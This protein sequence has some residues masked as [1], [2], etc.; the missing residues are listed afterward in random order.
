MEENENKVELIIPPNINDPLNLLSPV[1]KTEYELQLSCNANKK[2]RKRKRYKSGSE[3]FGGPRKKNK[4]GNSPGTHDAHAY[5]SNVSKESSDDEQTDPTWEIT[6]KSHQKDSTKISPALRKPSTSV[7][8]SKASETGSLADTSSKHEAGDPFEDVAQKT[9]ETKPVFQKPAHCQHGNHNRYYGFESLNKNMDVRLKIFQKNIHLFKNKDVL[10][11]GCNCG[12]L[13]LA[14]AKTFSPKSITGIDI[15]RKL[16]NIARSKLRKY[17]TVP[18]RII[19]PDLSC[20]ASKFRHKTECFPI[21]FPICYGNLSLALKQM[22]KKVQT[23]QTLSSTPQTPQ[24]GNEAQNSR[25]PDNISFE[26]VSID[27]FK[28][29]WHFVCNIIPINLHSPFRWTTCL[30]MKL[31]SFAMRENMT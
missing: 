20:D 11:I 23:P 4:T 28:I 13:T 9:D 2:K 7:D 17:V 14:I 24:G 10:D 30:K 27:Y 18:D 8:E 3:F 12:L 26:E 19:D 16:I 25:I 29:M 5:D 15:D 1:D 6:D 22:Q 31:V 21:S